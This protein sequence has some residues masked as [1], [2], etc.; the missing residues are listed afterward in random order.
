MKL[1]LI[2]F[3]I[4]TNI[5][6]IRKKYKHVTSSHSFSALMLWQWTMNLS[7][8]IEDEVF[9]VKCG[10]RGDNTWFFP[11][12]EDK[13]K[14]RIIASL[15]ANNEDGPLHFIYVR[16]EDLLFL[17]K[18]FGGRFSINSTPN[19][20]EY[21]LDRKEQVQIAGHNFKNVRNGI[22]Y[23]QKNFNVEVV[24]LVC[25]TLVN[26]LEVVKTWENHKHSASWITDDDASYFF[27]ENIEKFDCLG[28]V[29]KVDGEP[30]SLAAG[31]PLS[32]DTYDFLI[33]KQK[34]PESGFGSY[35][36]YQFFKTIPEKYKLINIEEDM[37]I[38]GLRKMKHLMRPVGIIDMYEA[39]EI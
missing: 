13:A 30:F 27:L 17:E 34:Y 8:Y 35:T 21:L 29:V 14:I 33:C 26:E 12:G 23:V 2:D 11:C 15:L 7:I 3:D 25:E 19:D 31:Y 36:K 32:D 16:K 20:S 38:E 4:K 37:G 10:K 28:I 24:P 18:Y 9:A 5:D 22:N 6:D 1:R 39:F